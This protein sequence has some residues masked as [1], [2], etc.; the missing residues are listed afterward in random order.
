MNRPVLIYLAGPQDDVTKEQSR[1]WREEIVKMA[2]SG[3][4]FFSPAHAYVDSVSGI[5]FKAVDWCNRSV[6]HNA[7]HGVIAKLDGPG[8][9][10]GTIREIEFAVMSHKPVAVVGDVVSLMSHD[11]GVCS[12]LEDALAYVLERVSEDRNQPSFME[13]ILGKVRDEDEDQ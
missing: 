7:V 4:A 13:Q 6:I 8:R 11:I 10:F 5:N 9:G 2:P 3:V 12:H 1:T